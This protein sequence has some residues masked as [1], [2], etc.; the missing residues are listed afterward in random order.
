MFPHLLGLSNNWGRPMHVWKALV[1][2]CGDHLLNQRTIWIS[3]GYHLDP[4]WIIC[5]DHL[6]CFPVVS[7]LLVLKLLLFGDVMF[8]RSDV[9]TTGTMGD[10][11]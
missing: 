3:F 5:G 2:I 11:D 9:K 7:Q 4:I 1:N 6:L 10:V 8:L